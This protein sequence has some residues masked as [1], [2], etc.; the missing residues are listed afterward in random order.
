[1][2]SLTLWMTRLWV[3]VFGCKFLDFPE[4]SKYTKTG[5]NQ[6]SNCICILVR[7]HFMWNMEF[8]TLDGWLS[9]NWCPWF[10]KFGPYF[11]DLS[12]FPQ[13][14]DTGIMK[15]SVG[16]YPWVRFHLMLNVELNTMDEFLALIHALYLGFFLDLP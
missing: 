14:T 9:V 5:T 7:L 11:P 12:Q 2:Y 16:L 4:C 1:M 8:N 15:L 13:N 3:R 10:G 6:P